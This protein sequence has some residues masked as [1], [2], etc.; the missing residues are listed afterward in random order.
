MLRVSEQDGHRRREGFVSSY[1]QL[2][3][4]LLDLQEAADQVFDTISQR[5]AEERDKLAEIS[6]RIQK[7]KAGIDSISS[8]KRSLII[9]SPSKYPSASA[10]ERDFRPLFGRKD[11]S[12]SPCVPVENILV[13]GGLKREFGLDGTL[14]LFQ[15]FTEANISDFPKEGHSKETMLNAMFICGIQAHKAINSHDSWTAHPTFWI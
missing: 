14:E 11:G 10:S 1:R 7:A 8:S 4:S 15:F 2:G 13:D 3:S 12:A 6:E 5:I 9:R